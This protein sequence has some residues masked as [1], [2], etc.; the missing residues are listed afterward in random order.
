[1]SAP[2]DDLLI[3]VRARRPIEAP[4]LLLVAHPDDEVLGASVLMSLARKLHLVHATTGAPVDGAED[5]STVSAGRFAELAAALQVLGV[6]PARQAAL[7]FP[8]GKLVQRARELALE[9]QPLLADAGALITHAFEGGHPDHDACALAVQLACTAIY[10]RHGW[11][12]ARYEFPLYRVGNDGAFATNRFPEGAW[13]EIA[14]IALRPEEAA[15][16][17]A[18]LQA[19]ASQAHVV[20][21]FSTGRE[22]LRTAPDYDFVTA[23]DPAQ[24]LYARSCGSA[25]QA[26]RE[27]ALIA[28]A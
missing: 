28:L 25:E 15:R 1:V 27:A 16:K 4:L 8:D 12:P 23:R 18:A 6:Q 20:E 14:D 9:L 5:G 26:W 10:R 22:Q 3:S 2:V 17:Q 7:K 19:F 21:H 13:G 11:C 24:L